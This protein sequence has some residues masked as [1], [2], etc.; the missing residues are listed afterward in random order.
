[1]LPPDSIPALEA[2]G[3]TGFLT[4]GQLH[5]GAC[6]DVPDERGLYV[7][8]RRG[9]APHEFMAR[10]SAP[11]WRGMD[12]SVSRDELTARW[13]AGATVLYVGSARGP[14]VRSRLRQRIKRYLRFGH[15]RVVSH[16]GGRL[17][18]QLREASRLVIAW[19]P[20]GDAEDPA[21]LQAD[22][23]ARFEQAHG[24]MPFANGADDVS[25]DEDVAE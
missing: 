6:L 17:I 19:R 9:D 25:D 22:L 1:M 2:D 11:A 14:G 15:G 21:Q 3:F 7:V 18:W 23:L 12:P 4:I 10:G 5:S 20:C 24:A 8:L 16:W 13:I